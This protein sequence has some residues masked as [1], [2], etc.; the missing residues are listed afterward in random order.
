MVNSGV[1]HDLD[2]ACRMSLSECAAAAPHQLQSRKNSQHGNSCSQLVRGN[3]RGQQAAEHDSGNATEE[4]LKKY[5][6]A[7]L[8]LIHI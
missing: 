2:W 8:S 6:K 7:D 3:F 1:R 5:R 4:K